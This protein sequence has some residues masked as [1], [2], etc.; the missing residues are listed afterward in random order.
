MIEV[1]AEAGVNHNGNLDI[2]MKMV[3][4]AAE[5]GADIVK[6]QTFSPDRLFHHHDPN[7]V[8]F[9]AFALKQKDFVKLAKYA[10]ELNIEFMSTPGDVDSL[11]FLVQEVGVRRIKIGSDD[12]TYNPLVE[13]ALATGLPVILSTGMATMKEI[14]RAIRWYDRSQLT[15][16]HCVS[17]YPCPF[18]KANLRAMEA[19]YKEFSCKIG[20]SDHVNGTLACVAAAAL[21]ACMIEKHFMLFE[22]MD[23]SPDKNV[24]IDEHVLEHMIVDIRQIDHMLGDVAKAPCTEER[25]NAIRWRKAEDGLRPVTWLP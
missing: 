4:A 14:E 18:E 6:F 15:L 20:Y 9:G 24:S 23:L 22:Y 12:L 19:L 3:E 5:A 1:C 25:E 7:Y 21:G 13:A 11:D 17:I 8:T 10:E 2:A 16:L